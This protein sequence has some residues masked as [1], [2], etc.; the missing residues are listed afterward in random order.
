M[1]LA[2]EAGAADC[3]AH[4][5]A[6]LVVLGYAP[7]GV[8]GCAHAAH[9]WRRWVPCSAV[10]W[11]CAVPWGTGFGARLARVVRGRA[12]ASFLSRPL[13]CTCLWCPRYPLSSLL[14]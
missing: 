7:V 12:R 2:P 1:T 4:P 3:R 8:T 6:P 13:G 9:R 14:A 5:L 11:G 10:V